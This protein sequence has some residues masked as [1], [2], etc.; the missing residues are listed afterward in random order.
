MSVWLRGAG[1]HAF[2]DLDDPFSS[3]YFGGFGNNWVDHLEIKRYREYYSLPGA[4]INTV[5]GRNFAKLT[6]ELMLPPMRF[7]RLG[8]TSAYF[9]WARVSLF[10]SG[11][12]TD[13]NSIEDRREL[14]SVGGQM[15]IRLVTFTHLR[16]TLS[17]GYAIAME[18]GRRM[19]EEL[20]ASL[21]IL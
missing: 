11:L 13:L 15:D 19:T 16:S 14:L 21:K 12:A 1:G 4:E 10:S 8:M 17:V 2:G 5:G 7:R 9:R 6:A 3:F 18:R 20:M